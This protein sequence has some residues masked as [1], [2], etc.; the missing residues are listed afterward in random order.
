MTNYW[1][2]A[3]GINQ[4][5]RLQPLMYAQRDACAI[6]QF[7]VEEAQFSVS[8]CRLLTDTSPAVEDHSTLPTR[9]SI[10][11]FVV[12]IC[13]QAIQPEDVLWFFW[14]GYA[15]RHRGRDYLLPMGG[16]PAQPVATGIP[17]SELF[18]TLR[19]A[20][21]QNVVV[22]LDMKRC[23]GTVDDSSGL[24]EHTLALA[25]EQNLA[26]FLACQPNQF[27]HETLALRQGLFT[28]ALL[29]GLRSYGC[30]TLAHLAQHL[31]DR[32]PELSQQHWRPQQDPAIVLPAEL[33]YQ[34]IL[35]G[36]VAPSD[37]P[38][39]PHVPGLDLSQP[40]PSA[41][42][43]LEPPTQLPPQPPPVNESQL[44]ESQL[45][46]SQLMPSP[47]APAPA[48]SPP[49]PSVEAELDPDAGE[50][51]WAT[52]LKWGGLVMGLLLVG[53]LIRNWSAL[54]GPNSSPQSPNGASG[55][56][57][58]P[59]P[60]GIEDT[61]IIPEDLVFDD[62][63]STT[64]DPQVALQRA[65]QAL[66]AGLPDEALRWLDQVPS[67][68]Q[69]EEYTQLRAEAER[70]SSEVGQTN[71]AILDEAIA[72]MNQTRENTPVN[73]ASDFH[74]AITQAS[75]IQPGQPLYEEAQ[76]AIQR[77]SRIIID[78]AEA[79]AKTGNYGDAIASAQLVPP[80]QAELRQIAEQKMAEWQTLLAQESSNVDAIAQAETLIQ[81]GNAS[82]YSDAIAQL[83][84]IQPGQPGYNQSRVQIDTW[85]RE[86]LA[87]A[88]DR[89]AADD[90]YEAVNAAAL[91]PEDSSVY[92]EARE[93]IAGWRQQLRGT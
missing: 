42:P 7:L 52:L 36:K 69:N 11:H 57:V 91:V 83:R 19:T 56:E 53:V 41:P 37:D 90:L 45:D 77:W 10:Q 43:T 38:L 80:N 63:A 5:Q 67:L 87:I 35:P 17:I 31:G 47:P 78:L 44:N 8:Q 3:I 79:R 72:S 46:E 88:Y 70:L 62:E 34:L 1:A 29:E 92:L 14:S 65:N 84:N 32:L 64:D 12:Q 18:A 93:A 24:G 60:N 86:I 50:H 81:P 68:A 49:N 39:P 33:R 27:S 48:P 25:E 75:R 13:Q 23:S 40:R 71:R 51:F 74:R 6:Q 28:T 61:E 59:A 82:S 58:M 9:E 55:A 21:T 26:V 4:Y 15:V 85:G 76:Q 22:L 54:R 30:A 16:D 20:P 66:A 2:I 73:Q 89:A